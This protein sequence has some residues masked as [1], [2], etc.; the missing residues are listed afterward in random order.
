[1]KHKKKN[2]TAE[3]GEVIASPHDKVV[4]VYL[5]EKETAESLFKEYLP[6]KITGKGAQGDGNPS[7]RRKRR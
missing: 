1:M 4:K 6:A 7:I 3:T 5:G 2:Q